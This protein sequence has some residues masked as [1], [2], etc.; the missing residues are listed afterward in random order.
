MADAE[1]LLEVDGGVAVVTLNA[2][3]RRN[4][5]TPQMAEELIGVFDEVDAQPEVGAGSVRPPGAA[6]QP[7]GL[8]LG[9]RPRACGVRDPEVRWWLTPRSCSRSTAAWRW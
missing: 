6:R 5:L 9:S 3:D 1:V 7:R 8:M 2:P 4:A